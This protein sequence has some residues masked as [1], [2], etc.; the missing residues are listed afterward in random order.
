MVAMS[1]TSS[2]DP[3]GMGSGHAKKHTTLHDWYTLE[4]GRYCILPYRYIAPKVLQYIVI[5]RSSS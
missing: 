5:L 4:L 2:L 1:Q 3:Y